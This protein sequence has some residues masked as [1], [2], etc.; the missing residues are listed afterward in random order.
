MCGKVKRY[1]EIV[2]KGH[3]AVRVLAG[4]SEKALQQLM[5]TRHL[6]H[7]RGRAVDVVLYAYRYRYVSTHIDRCI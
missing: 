1:L 4:G 6:R 7:V 2:H 3:H 5:A